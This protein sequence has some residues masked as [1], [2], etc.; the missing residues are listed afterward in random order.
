MQRIV[1]IGCPGS[2]KSTLARELGKRLDLPVS[3]LD[4]LYWQPGWQPP[5][6]RAA[7]DARVVAIAGTDRWIIDGS[8]STT[9]RQRLERA[10][11][12]IIMAFPRWRCLWRILVRRIRYAGVVRPDMGQG[13]PERIDT[14]LLTYVWNYR[15]KSL[16]RREADIAAHFRGALTRLASP[17]AVTSFATAATSAAACTSEA[18]R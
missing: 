7:F 5:A 18:S 14:E 2:G 17:R 6:D 13:C 12:V 3:H 16:P 9:L 15:R 11:T 8:Y 1:I 10:D 4:A